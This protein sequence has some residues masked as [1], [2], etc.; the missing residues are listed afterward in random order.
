VPQ[1]AG[2]FRDRRIS[3][4]V[5]FGAGLAVARH[6]HQDD[7]AIA[8]AQHVIAEVPLLERSRPE[9]LDDH[10]GAVDQFEKQLATGGLT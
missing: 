2:R 10:V 6:P 8:F 3:G 9:V 4:L 5:R 1:A 7:A